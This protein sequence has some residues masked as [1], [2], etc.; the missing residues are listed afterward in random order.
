MIGGGQPGLHRKAGSGITQPD[1]VLVTRGGHLPST[2]Q[3]HVVQGSD[4]AGD[5]MP[6]VPQRR[7]KQFGIRHRGI[8]RAEDVNPT[9]NRG[10]PRPV[11]TLGIERFTDS[12]RSGMIL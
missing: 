6:L 7:S 8:V 11:L 4:L 1:D 9:D 2:G 10:D 5:E 12:D 3:Q